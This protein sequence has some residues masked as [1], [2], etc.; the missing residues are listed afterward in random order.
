MG[1][2][3]IT[4]TG[5]LYGRTYF[6][7]RK[8]S[9]SMVGMKGKFSSMRNGNTANKRILQ[10][11][12]SCVRQVGTTQNGN[13]RS[14]R[15]RSHSYRVESQ[16]DRDHSRGKCARSQD[17][18]AQSQNERAESQ[19]QR[20]QSSD[21]HFQVQD[22]R[23]QSHDERAQSQ[24]ERVQS[25]DE[26]AQSQDER[27]QGQDIRAQSQH[28]AESRADRGQRDIQDS[29]TTNV[30]HKNISLKN[31]SMKAHK[32]PLPIS[33][34]KE[35]RFLNTIFIIACIAVVTVLVG[36][37]FAQLNHTVLKEWPEMNRVLKSVS[38]A[39]YSF[40][41]VFNP[42]VYCLRLKQYRKTFQM[43]Y[44]L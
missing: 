15:E 42:F 34:V 23:A 40:N 44:G 3:L 36:T 7:L 33:N 9:R 21:D 1:S 10:D 5:I 13:Q 22:E 17:E 11:S 31:S 41:F 29:S 16:T 4:L 14:K 30:I 26:R 6:T 8:Q 38:Y 28:V 18:H 12:E 32:K 19:C 20:A 27:A 24:D 43:V 2:L 39:I 37:V 25:Q 35:Q